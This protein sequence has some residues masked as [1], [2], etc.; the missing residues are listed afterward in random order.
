M[1]MLKLTNI[2]HLVCW[3]IVLFFQYCFG[4]SPSKIFFI[5]VRTLPAETKY[6]V[7]VACIQNETVILVERGDPQWNLRKKAML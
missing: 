3:I 6:T 4:Q 5:F 1:L 7:I 2:L